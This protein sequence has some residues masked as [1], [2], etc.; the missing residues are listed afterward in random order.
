MLK[1]LVFKQLKD[2]S[3]LKA[4]G[5]LE[6]NIDRENIRVCI[7]DNDGFECTGLELA[8]YKNIVVKTEYVEI[9]DFSS[10]D[11]IACDIVGIGENVSLERQGI[12]VAEILKKKYPDKTVLIYSSNNPI[13]YDEKYYL[14]AD[15][16]FRKSDSSSAIANFFDE[17]LKGKKDFIAAWYN[18]EKVFKSQNIPNKTI[19]FIEDQYVSSILKKQN[20]FEENRKDIIKKLK[21]T[22]DVVSLVATIVSLFI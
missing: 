6:K 18:L 2:I 10:Y 5:Y 20:L 9:N 14:I 17:R 21:V 22:M 1:E 13:E 3:L 12:A 4:N 8:G 7:L 15:G 16:F 19:A 11:L